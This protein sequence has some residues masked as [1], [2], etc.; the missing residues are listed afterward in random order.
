M[1]FLLEKSY[2]ANAMSSVGN[3]LKLVPLFS[4]ICF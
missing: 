4:W 3:R 2:L 1:Y